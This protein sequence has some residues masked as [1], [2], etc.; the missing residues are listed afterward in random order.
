M[1]SALANALGPF[2]AQLYIENVPTN[3]IT[4]GASTDH[5]I[6]LVVFFGSYIALTAY[7]I[8]ASWDVRTINGGRAKRALSINILVALVFFFIVTIG[9]LANRIDFVAHAFLPG[10]ALV[11]GREAPDF[12]SLT[13]CRGILTLFSLHVALAPDHSLLAEPPGSGVE[14]TI[15]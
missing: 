14:P 11:F 13:I 8:K 4:V 6:Q 15:A 7:L 9:F 3:G 2:V 10:H 5:A 1:G 12:T